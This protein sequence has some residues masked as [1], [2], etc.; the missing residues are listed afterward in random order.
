MKH[1]SHGPIGGESAADPH[2]GRTPRANE[3]SFS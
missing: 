3:M 2:D 1:N